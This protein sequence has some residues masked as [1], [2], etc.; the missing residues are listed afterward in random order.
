MISRHTVIFVLSF[1]FASVAPSQ[2]LDTKAASAALSVRVRNP[3]KSSAPISKRTYAHSATKGLDVEIVERSDGSTEEHPYVQIPIQFHAGS[4]ELRDLLSQRNVDLLSAVLR[5]ILA[6]EPGAR[7]VIQGHTS[8]EGSEA[9]NQTLSEKRANKI[10]SL[11]ASAHPKEFEHHLI[12]QGLGET[13]ARFTED[14][15]ESLRLKDRRVLVL[16]P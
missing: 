6:K 9:E 11:L 16:R 5:E 13:C 4:D 12:A 10:I 8:R 3:V 1:G 15:P 14:A 7:F 2:T